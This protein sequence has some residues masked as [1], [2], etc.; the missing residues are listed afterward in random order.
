MS[1]YF[2]EMSRTPLRDGEAPNSMLHMARF[3]R[4]SGMWDLLWPD[5]KLPPPASKDAVENLSEIKIESTESKQCP[6]CLKEFEVD[7][8]AKL[9][10]CQHVFHQECII[11][12]LQKT[13]SCPLCRYELPTDDEDYEM[14]RKEKKRA[15][16][17]ERDLETLHN[18]MFS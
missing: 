5:A 7:D 11:P 12:W 2:E 15:V 3:L 9:M 18:S 14:Y 10:P 13:N 17:R 16:E 6:V 1:D 4:D 8:K